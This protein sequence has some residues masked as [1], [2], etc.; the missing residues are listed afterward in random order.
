MK[1]AKMKE[2]SVGQRVAWL[3]EGQTGR[4]FSGRIVA[5]RG[6]SASIVVDGVEQRCDEREIGQHWGIS[7][8]RLQAQ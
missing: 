6:F 2:F 4:A 5:I 1:T 8:D 3:H 7:L